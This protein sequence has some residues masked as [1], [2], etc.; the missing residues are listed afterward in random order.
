MTKRKINQIEFAQIVLKRIQ[1][2]QIKSLGYCDSRLDEI[3]RWLDYLKVNPNFVNY[4]K[5]L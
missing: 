3:I 4:V 1:R 5:D 2:C